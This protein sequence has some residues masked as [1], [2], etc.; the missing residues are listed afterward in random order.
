MKQFILALWLALW[1]ISALA[2]KWEVS[3][4]LIAT[5]SKEPLAMVNV[6]LLSSDSVRIATTNTNEVGEFTLKA[7]CA[8]DYIVVARIIG[9]EVLLSAKNR[10]VRNNVSAVPINRYCGFIFQKVSPPI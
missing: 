8:R 3:G 5:D 2:Q 7:T 6:Q 4:C 9:F 1:S 10:N